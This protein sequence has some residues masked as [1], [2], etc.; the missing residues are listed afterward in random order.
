MNFMKELNVEYL[1]LDFK[2]PKESECYKKHSD[3]VLGKIAD[4]IQSRI[5]YKSCSIQS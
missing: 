1:S 4:I 2:I 3:F 5:V